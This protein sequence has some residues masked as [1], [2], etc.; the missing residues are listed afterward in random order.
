[1]AKGAEDRAFYRHQR[2]SSLCE[3]GGR[4]GEWSISVDE[5]HRHQ[6]DMQDGWPTNMLTDTTH[7]T[8]RSSGVRARSLAM[9][10][11][12]EATVETASDWMGANADVVDPLRPADVSLA[13]QTTL[14]AWPLDVDRLHAYLVKST[15]EADRDT[16][17]FEPDEPYESALEALAHRLVT[18]GN[19]DSSA[20]ARHTAALRQPGA[21]VGL[22]LAALQLMCPGVPDLYQ[23]APMALHSLVDP[24]NRRPP[25]WERF[26]ALLDG[27]EIDPEIDPD[28]DPDRAR[29]ALTVRLL[30][31]R[32]RH[33]EAFGRDA[34][35]RP[36]VVDGPHASSVIAFTRTAGDR[37]HRADRVAVIAVRADIEP[38]SLAD[39]IIDLGAT[40]W[41]RVLGV[42]DPLAVGPIAVS[43]LVGYTGVEVLAMTSRA[44]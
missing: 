33:P 24:D 30:A 13:I 14:T 21:A 43:A 19:D 35:Y 23:G 18:D 4:P 11:L 20:L 3:V 29:M 26:A 6:E 9:A 16:N 7:D 42:G 36:I 41:Q 15:R 22:R 17:W 44:E 32:R 38:R 12:S 8:K 2:L 27:A 28:G 10:L 39:T 34:G 40:G 31:L 1:M 25:D 37:S 5:F